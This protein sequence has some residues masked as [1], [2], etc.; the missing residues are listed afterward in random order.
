MIYKSELTKNYSVE[1]LLLELKKIRKI[2]LGNGKKIVSEIT[3]KQSKIMESLNVAIN[4]V[5]K[6]PR[7]KVILCNLHLRNS[8][9]YFIFVIFLWQ[10]KIKEY[11]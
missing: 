6:N 1:K 4:Y 5:P 2:V 3:K 10:H 8:C 7:G 11:P 9:K